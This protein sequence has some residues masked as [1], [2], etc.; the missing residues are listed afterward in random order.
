MT[1]LPEG[2]TIAFFDLLSEDI[3]NC[4]NAAYREGEMAISRRRDT[5]T[6]VP[7]LLNL[8]NWRPI[9][10]LNLEYKIA[11]KVIAKSLERELERL[12]NR[13]QTGFGKGRCIGQNIRFINEIL[14]QTITQNIPGILLQLDFKKAFNTI[15][16][17]FIK[18]TLALFNF[19]DSFQEVDINSLNQFGE[20]R[21]EYMNNGFCTSPFFCL[22]VCFSSFSHKSPSGL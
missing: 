16:F 11:S 3:I 17:E 7:S 12:I 13:D 1:V 5:I 15:E 9:T 6:L 20:L 14:E 8:A 21:Y 10:L 4:Y 19:G 18:K 22:F 2:S